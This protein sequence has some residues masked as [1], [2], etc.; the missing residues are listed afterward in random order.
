VVK[1]HITGAQLEYHMYA[2]DIDFIN[3][4]I[5]HHLKAL[6]ALILIRT[7]P[8]LT[9]SL[10]ACSEGEGLVNLIMC[11]D[12]LGHMVDIQDCLVSIAGVAAEC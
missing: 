7:R 5:L 4:Y 11:S 2:N 10:V 12:V 3:L 6:K 9:L 1:L 8:S